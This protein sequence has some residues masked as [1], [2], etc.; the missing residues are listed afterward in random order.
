MPLLACCEATVHGGNR[1]GEGELGVG[2]ERGERA[3]DGARGKNMYVCECH[4]H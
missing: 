3:K 2:G 4:R 1:H